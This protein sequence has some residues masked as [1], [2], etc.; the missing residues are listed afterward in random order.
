[1][2][3]TPCPNACGRSADPITI[4]AG[5]CA[6]CRKEARRAAH[7]GRVLSM[8][9]VRRDRDRILAASDKAHLPDF[10][11][12][13]LTAVNTHRQALRDLPDTHA[14]DVPGAFAQ[15]ATIKA[16]LTGLGAL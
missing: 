16:A 6:H 15:L 8:D 1:M 5:L 13:D 3:L 12:S 9:D 14:G 2:S 11:V 4:E 10:P 7:P